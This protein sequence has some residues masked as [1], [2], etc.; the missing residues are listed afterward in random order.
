MPS[1]L[2]SPSFW[3]DICVIIL[4]AVNFMTNQAQFSPWVVWLGLIS[5]VV[6]AIEVAIKASQNSSLAKKVA[7]RD[8]TIKDF[9]ARFAAVNHISNP[10]I[11]NVS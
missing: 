6:T 4:A 2:K 11:P 5:T 1:W 3:I 7:E 9:T 8:A 10:V